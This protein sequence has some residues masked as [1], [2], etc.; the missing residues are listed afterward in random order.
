MMVPVI[1]EAPYFD[2]YALSIQVASLVGVDYY[3]T[4]FTKDGTTVDMPD[5]KI[6]D[7]GI[8]K[9]ADVPGKPELPYTAN[10]A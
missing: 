5:V 10:V 3:L 4:G 1:P 6:P 8:L 7:G 9:L 2:K